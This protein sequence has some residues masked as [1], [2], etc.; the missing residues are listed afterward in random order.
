MQS[1]FERQWLATHHNCSLL[2]ES[3]TENPPHKIL[4]VGLDD[5]L[6]SLDAFRLSESFQAMKPVPEVKK[7]F[8]EHGELARHIALTA[9][10]LSAASASS[11]WVFKHFG[12]WIRTYHFVPS[13]R[14]GQD[15]PEY[16]AGKEA[17]LKWTGKVEIMVDDNEANIT[18]AEKAGVRGILMPQRWNGSRAT[19]GEALSRLTE[20][21]KGMRGHD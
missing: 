5:Y 18:G 20:L 14:K 1:W 19:V 3:I 10:P 6:S 15:I 16:D 21:L 4:N 9:V 17:F 2:Y 8:I 12:T 13:K 11:A 7:W